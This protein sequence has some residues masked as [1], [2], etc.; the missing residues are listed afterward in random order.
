MN[1]SNLNELSY[2]LL[3]KEYS[4]DLFTNS[5]TVWKQLISKVKINE[6]LCSIMT[7]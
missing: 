7:S 4:P 3:L 1:K 6:L 2:I 5:I